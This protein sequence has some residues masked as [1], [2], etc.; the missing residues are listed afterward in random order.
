M[1][2]YFNIASVGRKTVSNIRNILIRP[3]KWLGFAK[4]KHQRVRKP[5]L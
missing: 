2:N 3:F 5:L 1:S 4:K